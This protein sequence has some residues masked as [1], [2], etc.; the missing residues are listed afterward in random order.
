MSCPARQKQHEKG[1]V[2]TT[3]TYPQELID[4]GLGVDDFNPFAP[5]Y[6]NMENKL[7]YKPCTIH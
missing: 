7:Q 5:V 4:Q 1:I 3:R 2:L 6:T